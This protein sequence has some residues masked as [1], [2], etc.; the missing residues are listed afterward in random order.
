VIWLVLRRSRVLMAITVAALVGLA[1]WMIVL[2]HVSDVTE[3]SFACTHGR[4]SCSTRSGVFSLSDQATAINFLLL[5]VPCLLGVVYGAPLVAGELE[6]STNR[7]AWTQ[8]VS[9]TKWLIVKWSVIGL[10]LVVSLAALTFVS[11]W[12]TG[13]A[14]ETQNLN[15]WL[16][17]FGR[18]R[19]QPLYFPVTG[20]A[21]GAYTLFAFALSAALGAVIRKTSWAIFAAV[22]GYT[23]IAVIAVFFVRPGLA[24]QVFAP[25]ATTTSGY[26]QGSAGV[27]SDEAWDLGYGYRYAPGTPSNEMGSSANAVGQQ[28]NDGPSFAQCFAKHHL[29]M[30]TFYQPADHYWELQW[31]ESALLVLITGALLGSTIWSVRRWRA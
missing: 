3:S 1:V 4:F 14:N 8:G 16:A 31:R 25:F 10:F 11:Q 22:I 30:G 2:G 19:L 5:L 18:G 17:G 24:P 15:L 12:W 27:I 21:L 13:Q 6:H 29:Q 9:R 28:C 26:A 7:L 23:A 20:L